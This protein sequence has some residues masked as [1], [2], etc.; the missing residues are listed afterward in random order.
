MS[1]SAAPR[2][3]TAFRIAATRALAERR[4]AAE[5]GARRST[6]ALKSARSGTSVAVPWPSA[7]IVGV[8]SVCAAA[9]AARQRAA[10]RVARAMRMPVLLPG[11]APCHI[12]LQQIAA[13]VVD[14]QGRVLDVVG[15]VEEALERAA[16]GVA[17]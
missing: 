4:A 12:N 7:A 5:V 11:G 6:P 9:G 1:A 13:F 15:V 8:V 14:L 3:L 16:G 17:V 10:A 2:A